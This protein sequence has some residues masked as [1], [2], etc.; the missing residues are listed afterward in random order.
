MANKAPII[1]SSLEQA[2]QDLLDDKLG[3][4]QTLF[5]M[6][7]D[8]DLGNDVKGTI[9]MALARR[10][11]GQTLRATMKLV[12]HSLIKQLDATLDNAQ[13]TAITVAQKRAI[14]DALARNIAYQ[15]VLAAQLLIEYPVFQEA[16]VNAKAAP[17]L[18]KFQDLEDFEAT[19]KAQIRQQVLIDDA[20][21]NVGRIVM[22]DPIQG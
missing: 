1:I 9:V 3:T 19:R 7:A 2:F 8:L 5:E 20:L 18:P 21:V 15:L 22:G 4:P 11:Q 16:V 13:I 10:L 17:G 6:F 12:A 14:A